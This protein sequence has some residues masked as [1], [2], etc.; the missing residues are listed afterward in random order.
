MT[1][2][3]NVGRFA[4]AG[5]GL[6]GAVRRLDRTVSRTIDPTYR[7]GVAYLES[8]PHERRWHT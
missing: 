7:W 2:R 5:T 6:G 3:A 8:R 4:E 1:E